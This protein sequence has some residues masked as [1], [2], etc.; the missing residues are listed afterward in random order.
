M[1][2]FSI[3]ARIDAGWINFYDF[4][5]L[6]ATVRYVYPQ[7]I[8]GDGIDEVIFAGFETQPNTPSEYSNTSLHIFGWTEGSLREITDQ[9]LPNGANKVEGVGDIGFGDFNGDGLIDAFLSAYADMDYQTNTY[10]LI[11]RGDHFEKAVLEYQLAWQHGV[12][13]EDINQDGFSD[14]FATGYGDSPRL[15]LGSTNGLTA[16]RINSFAGGSGVTLADFYGDNTV[17][18][19]LV[20]HVASQNQDTALFRFIPVSEGTLDINLSSSLPLARFDLDQYGPRTD[21]LGRSHDVRI[22]SYDFSGD[23][24]SDAIVFSRRSFD[25]DGW[26]EASEI[27]FLKNLGNGVFVDVTDSTLIGYKHETNIAYNP[28]F[29]DINSDGLTDI[30]LSESA[31]TSTYDSTAILLHQ[32]DGTFLDYG[33][34]ELSSLI[35]GL[36][37]MGNLTK[38]PNGDFYLVALELDWATGLEKVYAHQIT[39][40]DAP[41]GRLLGDE[42]LRGDAYDNSIYGY[43]GNDRLV[44]KRGNDLLDGGSGTDTSEYAQTKANY[45]IRPLNNH[46]IV[47]GPDGNDSL[48]GVERLHFS[49]TNIAL[50]ITGTAGQAYRIYKAA[51]DRAPDTGGLGFWIDAMDEGA[52]LTNVAAGFIASP[53]FQKL[54]GANVSDRDFLTKLYNNVLD[55]NPDQG[56]YD[57]WLGALENGTTREDILVNFSESKENIANVADLIAN[58]IQYQEWLG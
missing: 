45:E 10:Q 3:G 6:S 28:I 21:I 47:S 40:N 22:E 35:S 20:D 30:F 16:Y 12:A 31:Y 42:I 7:D 17:S 9:W 32:Q 23:G 50:D 46:W 48:F 55:R 19:I 27:Q 49:D 11:N 39:S 5:N 1:S 26:P 15:Y 51:F 33:R 13:V 54:C 34:T 24:L 52:S 44:G 37:G 41:I 36:G 18:A 57:F 25:G 8:N 38:G 14:V 2:D 43:G 56:G 29:V 58:G 4:R 53:E